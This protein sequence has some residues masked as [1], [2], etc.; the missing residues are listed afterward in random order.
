VVVDP[1]RTETAEIADEHLFIRPG[2]DAALLLAM[3]HVIFAEGRASPRAAEERGLDELRAIAARFPPERV[4]GAIG[5]DAATIRGLARDFA[6]TDGAVAYGRIGICQS[7]FGSV[8]SW[9]VEA[10]NVV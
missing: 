1:R 7:A 2:G 6:A 5:I 3:L 9:L 10:L 8:G 4:A